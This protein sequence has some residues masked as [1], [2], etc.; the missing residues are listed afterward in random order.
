MYRIRVKSEFSGAHWLR[1]YEGKCENLHGHNWKVEVVGE[2]KNLD[3]SGLLIDF[4]IVKKELK[5]IL[6]TLDH[7]NLNDHPYFQKQ[8]P[9]SENIARYIF[10][11]LAPIFL[12][13][14]AMLKEVTVWENDLQSASYLGSEQAAISE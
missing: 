14:R 10:D 12:K 13:Y 8:N 11:Q 9:T 1:E 4:T 7:S 2:A 3:K 5:N 6:S